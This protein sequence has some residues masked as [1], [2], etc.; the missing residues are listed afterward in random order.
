M[1]IADLNRE[2][3]IQTK[4]V[5]VDEIGNHKSKWSDF[6]ETSAYISFQGKGEEVFLGMEMDH[7]DVSFTV[8]FQSKLKSINTS[9][10]R[11]LFDDEKY[12][13]LSIKYALS[14]I[15]YCSKCGDIYRR[16]VW[17][18][19][20]KK[21]AVWRC[22]TRV[23]QGSEECDART[24]RE[25]DLQ[26]AVIEAVN[27]LIDERIELKEIIKKNIETVITGNSNK[28]IEEIDEEILKV[29]EELL[30]VANAKEDYT[31]LANQ[32][33]KLRSKKEK[34]L[35]EIAEE[36]NAQIRLK[37]LE[38]FLE[39]QD[40]EIESYDE[41]L[42]RKLIEKIVVYEENIKVIFKSGFNYVLGKRF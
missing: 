19:R 8:R 32:V 27:K 4:T 20:G 26:E 16:I 5:E 34:T 41:E 35:L 29:Q 33:E 13:I 9:E 36:K 37:E 11:I 38:D 15:V 10:Y 14:S 1:K 39:Y 12:N 6:L 40:F 25:T 31:D 24:I 30:K 22:C 3:K 2:I 7:A 21:Y 28:K 17:N 23:T 42:V 18:N